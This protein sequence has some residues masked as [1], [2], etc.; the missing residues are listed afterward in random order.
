MEGTRFV[1]INGI[2][3]YFA[4]WDSIERRDASFCADALFVRLPFLSF[5][6][7]PFTQI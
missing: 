5:I 6:G 4:D 3:V 1:L 7:Y 2:N